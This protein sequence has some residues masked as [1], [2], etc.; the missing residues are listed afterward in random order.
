MSSLPFWRLDAKGGESVGICIVL[1]LV[2]LL[3]RLNL[4]CLCVVC[5]FE[6]YPTY[7]VRHMHSIYLSYLMFVL[8]CLVINLS[9]L[10]NIGGALFLV[11]V[12]HA[13]HNTHLSGTH[14]GGARLYY[15]EEGF[16]FT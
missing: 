15:R 14:L 1:C 12:C 8:S 9:C 2:C 10:Y 3:C 5:A 7:G 16:A 4:V 6:T 11:F 13:V